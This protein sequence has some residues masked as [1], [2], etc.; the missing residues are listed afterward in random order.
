MIEFVL[1]M[2]VARKLIYSGVIHLM[3]ETK[4]ELIGV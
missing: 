1:C 4:K 3:L 2:P